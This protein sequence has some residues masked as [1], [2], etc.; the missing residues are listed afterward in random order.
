MN[1]KTL[2][3][4]VFLLSLFTACNMAGPELKE[5]SGQE[6]S[7]EQGQ[8]QSPVEDGKVAVRL[9]IEAE[10][11]PARTVRPTV[12]LSDA[13]KWRLSGAKDGGDSAELKEF[14]GDS[15]TIYLE[16]G[17]WDFVLDGFSD[18]E[19]NT[20]ILSGSLEN[21]T[22]AAADDSNSLSFIV[23]PVLDGT[24]TVKLTV[25][26]PAGF[27]SRVDVAQE[28]ETPESKTPSP[29]SGDSTRE[30]IV[31]EAS[32]GT[33]EYYFII[34]LWK[35]NE[36][37]GVVSELVYVRGGLTSKKTYELQQ[38]DLNLTYIINYHEWDGLGTAKV[39]EAYYRKTDADKTLSSPPAVSGYVFKGWYETTAPLDLDQDDPAFNE[40]DL[41]QVITT[42][43]TD[44]MEHKHYYPYWKLVTVPSSLNLAQSL[45][46]ISSHVEPNQT[47]TI[48]VKLDEPIDPQ[49]LS[50]NGQTV[51]IT[52]ISDSTERI[53]SLSSNGSLFM[54]ENGVTLTLGSNITLRGKSGN[55]D[56]LVEV[57][58][59]GVLVMESGS[60]ITGNSG[61]GVFVHDSGATFEMN[62]GEISG[63][64]GSSSGGVTVANS[65]TFEM[66]GGKISGNTVSGYNG[67]GV[68]VS[69]SDA[70]FEMSGGEI[71]G[72]T[73][74]GYNGGGV[75]VTS[76][77]TFEMSG[78]E[79]SDNSASSGGGVYVQGGTFTMSDGEISGN[80]VSGNGDLPV[81]AVFFR[82]VKHLRREPPVALLIQRIP[83]EPFLRFDLR[84]RRIGRT[85][86][87]VPVQ[88]R[89]VVNA[90]DRGPA[91]KMERRPEALPHRI[92]IGPDKQLPGKL[93][94][95]IALPDI[96]YPHQFQGDG[97]IGR[98]VQRPAGVVGRRLVGPVDGLP[99][100][101]VSFAEPEAVKDLLVGHGVKIGDGSALFQVGPDNSLDP[102]Y[103]IPV[104]EPPHGKGPEPEL[105]VEI[106]IRFFI[107]GDLRGEKAYRLL[108]GQRP[109]GQVREEERIVGKVG[110]PAPLPAGG[111]HPHKAG[112]H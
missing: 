103:R 48:T 84:P 51:G 11:A 27:I 97:R 67:G 70:T 15:D 25:T 78:G 4:I 33:G 40:P 2:S 50:Y 29:V 36:L 18:N 61:G 98:K 3:V 58:S 38:A 95:N 85:G 83:A 55:S 35:D 41:S 1:K 7:P 102:V 22:I 96:L 8:E 65:G 37:Y 43:D 100:G 47:Y 30:S 10:G 26:M 42:L 99:V 86:A 91:I 49:T 19:C 39:E 112:L 45:A 9:H 101:H 5:S 68:I 28:G 90:P 76:S 106:V 60:K 32:L 89:S 16:A 93:I 107:E 73:V 75:Y 13:A 109:D 24:G 64:T 74:S 23:A 82:P 105:V 12:A 31:F 88:F 87:A 17:S 111:I 54:V 69:G 57:K 53:V 56:S 92:L 110:G 44:A 62:G 46:W 94:T 108:I 80:T 77:G 21:Q 14:T 6:Q 79:I 81:D 66:N 34:K 72:N 63:N 71:S 52:L 104:V 59:G 20:L